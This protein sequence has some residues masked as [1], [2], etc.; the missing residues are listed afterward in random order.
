MSERSPR[1]PTRRK[2]ANKALQG[3]CAQ[4]RKP[5]E[6][7][8]RDRRYCNSTCRVYALRQRRAAMKKA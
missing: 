1:V 4:C 7:G 6:T 2:R 5:L 8:R 3:I